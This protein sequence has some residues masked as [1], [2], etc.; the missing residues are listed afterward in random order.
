[1][2]SLLLIYLKI[3]NERDSQRGDE[4]QD[5]AGYVSLSMVTEISDLLE[6][7]HHNPQS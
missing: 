3:A 2:S 7:D 1:M 6:A 4:S 5:N